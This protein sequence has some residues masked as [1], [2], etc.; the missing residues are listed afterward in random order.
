MYR[1]YVDEVGHNQVKNL[2]SDRQK[3][4]SLTGVAIKV[5]HSRDVLEPAINRIKAEIFDHDPDSPICFH[6]KEI[7]GFKGPYEKLRDE[8]LS[9]N[10]DISILRLF[11]DTEYTVITA[12]ID[13][14]WMLRQR[15]WQNKDSYNILMEILAEKYAQFLER[16]NSYGDIMPEGRNK[17]ANR[18]LQTAFDDV[19][20]NG[21]HYVSAHRMKYRIRATKLKFRTKQDNIAGLQLCD[22]LA[23]PSHIYVRQQMNHAV[24]LGPFATKVIRILTDRKYDRNPHSGTIRGYGYKHLP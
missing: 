4:L 2:N 21:T 18:Q 23:H 5:N 6:R 19:M 22:L 20:N 12:L 7:M 1:L 11:S 15:H 10:F 9:E 8:T 16:N 13:K 24:T 3:F 14:P 17:I